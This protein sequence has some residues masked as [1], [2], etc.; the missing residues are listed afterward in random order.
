[1]VVHRRSGSRLLRTIAPLLALGLVL[2]SWISH[3][4]NHHHHHHYYIPSYFAPFFSA[5]ATMTDATSSLVVSARQ[6]GTSSPPRITFGVTNT[7]PRPVTVLAWDSP[8]DPLALQLGRVAVTPSGDRQPLDFPTVQVRRR[9]PP[10]PDDLVTIEP[11]ETAENEVVLREA[12][13]PPERLGG[14]ATVVCRGDWAAV[15]PGLRAADVG[16][17][18]RAELG[19]NKDAVKGTYES[20]PLEIEV[21][22]GS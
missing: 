16:E 1:M 4:Q 17:Q 10:G 6:T 9:M 20:E 2:V 21:D 11:G 12:L 8:L 5:A 14:R 3:S 18:A 15:W 7:S 19:A 22:V 13:L